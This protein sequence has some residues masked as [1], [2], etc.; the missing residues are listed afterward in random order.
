VIH[1]H[2]SR[3]LDPDDPLLRD[4]VSMQLTALIDSLK[5]ADT[6]SGGTVALAFGQT[7]KKIQGMRNVLVHE[8][9][10]VNTDALQQT[11]RHDLGEVER[12]TRE[13]LDTTTRET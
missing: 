7:W 10:A 13:L 11:V 8:Y 6:A 1:D 5:S 9:Y 2:T 4:A 12:L 3:G